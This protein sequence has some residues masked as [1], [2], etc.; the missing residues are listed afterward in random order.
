MEKAVKL[1][2]AKRL[3]SDR[4]ISIQST[5]FRQQIRYPML[6]FPSTRYLTIYEN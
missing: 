3:D 6:R 4:Y 2:S 1:L 5:F